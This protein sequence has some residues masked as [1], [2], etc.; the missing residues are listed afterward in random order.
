MTADQD[1]PSAMWE[2]LNHR[3]DGLRRTVAQTPAESRGW[4]VLELCEALITRFEF[5][6]FRSEV[7]G[8]PEPDDLLEVVDLSAVQDG[9]P[10]HLA[11]IWV[12]IPRAVAQLYLTGD[13]D[14]DRLDD[15]VARLRL[16]RSCPEVP[17]ETWAQAGELLGR[18][19]AEYESLLKPDDD[20][21]DP[22]VAEAVELLD[23]AEQLLDDEAE[24]ADAALLAGRLRIGRR[25]RGRWEDDPATDSVEL[26]LAIDALGQATAARIVDGADVYLLAACL[27]DRYELHGNQ[28]DRS[29]AVQV[30]RIG[31]E[32]P[33]PDGRWTVDLLELLATTLME[34]SGDQDDQH[35]LD[36]AILTLVRARDAQPYGQRLMAVVTLGEALLR[37]GGMGG[38]QPVEA[39]ELLDCLV[40]ILDS[41]GGDAPDLEDLVTG[42]AGI[43]A[44]QVAGARE[45]N[46]RRDRALN[47]LRRQLDLGCFHAGPEA[48]ALMFVGLLLTLR[49]L[50]TVWRED[51]LVGVPG[52]LRAGVDLLERALDHPDLP[53]ESRDWIHGHVAVC[54]WALAAFV[55][56]WS[57]TRQLSAGEDLP[58]PD[59]APLIRASDHL[60]HVEPTSDFGWLAALLAIVLAVTRGESLDDDQFMA[61]LDEIPAAIL[62]DALLG[63]WTLPL[64]A[65]A[66]Y[67]RAAQDGQEAGLAEAV[68]ALR[69]AYRVQPGGFAT[70]PMLLRPLGEGLGKLA[71][72]RRDASLAEEA[73]TALLRAIPLCVGSLA[74]G[75]VD[76]L[77]TLLIDART[78][79]D[80][81][82]SAAQAVEVLTEE[83][84]VEPAEARRVR[85]LLA[86][87]AASELA[88][89][90]PA[91]PAGRS[92]VVPGALAAQG[93]PALPA[94]FS[95]S[96]DEDERSRL[97]AVIARLDVE[98]M[99]TAQVMATAAQA[100]ALMEL[101]AAH[102][103]RARLIPPHVPADRPDKLDPVRSD[104]ALA[105]EAARLALREYARCVLLAD[106]TADGLAVAIRAQAELP[107]VVGWCVESGE[108]DR[109]VE[110]VEGGRGL[111]LAAATTFGSV[112]RL[113]I[114]VGA[115]ELAQ[116]WAGD[117]TPEDVRNEALQ[118]LGRSVRG[119][120][121][122]ASTVSTVG[123]ISVAVWTAGVDAVVYLL[124]PNGNGD[125][126]RALIVHA[127]EGVEQLPLAAF[128][129]D[130][131]EVLAGYRAAYARAF[132][133]AADGPVRTDE[134]VETAVADWRCEL[135][136]LGEWAYARVMGPLL[137]HLRGWGLLRPPRIVLV[138]MG[139]MAAVPWQAA[140]TRAADGS[141]RYAVEEL[142]LSYA[143]SA[144][145]LADAGRRER[146]PL[147]D[148][149]ALVVDPAGDLFWASQA[150]TAIRDTFY[151]DA[152]YL[153]R[154]RPSSNGRRGTAESLLNLL[155]ARG[156]DG[157]SMLQVST[158]AR[159]GGSPEDTSLMLEDGALPVS[160]ILERARHRAPD[161]PG[162]LVVCDACITDV[163]VDAQD[164]ALTLATAFLAAGAVSVIGTRWPVED[165][166]T[167]VMMFMFHHFLADGLSRPADA[168]RAAVLWMLDP[169]RAVPPRMPIMLARQARS[170]DL[171]NPDAW[172]GFAHHGQ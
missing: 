84:R 30:L 80:H 146:L 133:P 50:M 28:Q 63:A 149:P 145:Q 139:T 88:V 42:L 162:G 156:A 92:L 24:Q 101:A 78:V 100:D 159:A 46:P 77:A 129:P 171:A 122:Q 165:L 33:D 105:F 34:L 15:A 130:D 147:K 144:R 64:R 7:L 76:D 124:P 31:L 89:P 72:L 134:D 55:P 93:L 18:A 87:Q 103:R 5:R 9:E 32:L 12:G 83:L 119:L 40:E 36:E 161:A 111:V 114:D 58:S 117:R 118:V 66:I 62:E 57:S 157:A 6:L 70:V 48:V 23:Q 53:P 148:S 82:P 51:S 27:T 97:D 47:L 29:D 109:A 13:G 2:V 75:A 37:R 164:E 8:E 67:Y 69:Q 163:A 104:D 14:C 54:L 123:D 20:R 152:A 98:T 19:L 39:D 169:D 150:G 115:P 96:A 61:L 91:T 10:E 21:L 108:L 125:P 35:A 172:A 71:V 132:A 116:Q 102:R 110:F 90:A 153:G 16:V 106:A 168:L 158:H 154:P 52:D 60:R 68:T 120:M 85:L 4:P 135:R 136:S 59:L 38:W 137:E 65:I 43:A 107:M 160:R 3:I 151:P 1:D 155:P 121:L 81:L 126:A 73:L 25:L 113:L 141:V 142:V 79:T 167:A 17:A 170:R 11:E 128:T 99:H 44:V 166:S 22:L 138:P 127:P 131:D 112:S 94:A 45:W 41:P 140:W 74:A 95:G 26:G 86:L 49:G 56:G 143:A